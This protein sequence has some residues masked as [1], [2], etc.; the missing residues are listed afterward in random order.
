M[1]GLT[2]AFIGL[3]GGCP[4]TELENYFLRRSDP[5]AAYS[6]GFIAHALARIV[7]WDLPP[8]VIGLASSFWFLVWGGIYLRL[9][10]REGRRA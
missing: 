6:G 3:R 1:M 4:L 7:Y 8:G 10:L 9:W 5:S 2:L